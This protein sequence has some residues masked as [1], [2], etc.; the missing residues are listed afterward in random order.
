MLIMKM[1]FSL[2]K[3]RISCWKG[4]VHFSQKINGMIEPWKAKQWIRELDQIFETMVCSE[5]DKR[6]LAVFQLTYAVADWKESEKARFGEVA[7]R[8]MP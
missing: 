3:Q 8:M 6:C 5:L 2:V 1:V 4:S 7:V